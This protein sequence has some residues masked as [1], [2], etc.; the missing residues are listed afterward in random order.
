MPRTIRVG[1]RDPASGALTVAAASPWW[2]PA[3]DT[4]YEE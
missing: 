3:D 4:E 2:P 1:G